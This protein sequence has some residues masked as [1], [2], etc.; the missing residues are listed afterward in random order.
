MPWAKQVV[1]VFAKDVRAQRWLLLVFVA[2]LTISTVG[3]LSV[4]HTG[5]LA[6][7]AADASPTPFD[8]A[9]V[10]NTMVIAG[11]GEFATT[12][13]LDPVSSSFAQIL[14]PF[15]AVL[16]CALIV[17][18]DS[19]TQPSAFWASLPYSRSAVWGA[20]LLFVMALLLATAITWAIPLMI[21]DLT[22]SELPVR[23]VTA[24]MPI[25]LMCVVALLLATAAAELRTVVLFALLLIV[26]AL[27]GS[28]LF[29][30]RDGDWIVPTMIWLLIRPV[31]VIAA[32]W[33]LS[34]VYRTR[35]GARRARIASVG[36]AG[37]VF[38][39]D[40]ME[41]RA[42][43]AE[44]PAVGQVIPGAVITSR[45]EAKRGLGNDS[46]A[47]TWHVRST[48]VPSTMRAS[49]QLGSRFSANP[50]RECISTLL[51][52]SAKS[53]RILQLPP[54]P[55]DGT[56]RWPAGAPRTVDSLSFSVVTWNGVSGTVEADCGARALEAVL[57]LSEAVVFAVLPLQSG[58]RAT[59][60]GQRVEV[61]DATPN[62]SA[63]V[64][65]VVTTSANRATFCSY[66]AATFV[67]VNRGQG[68]AVLLT[69]T[70]Q[71]SGFGAVVCTSSL[72]LSLADGTGHETTWLAMGKRSAEESAAWL[73]DAQLVVIEW[74]PRATV[75]ITPTFPEGA[76]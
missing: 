66:E 71:R 46:L 37:L 1:H 59:G 13:N 14:A 40:V 22:W 45:L 67:L 70:R 19:P 72:I 7:A 75:S 61:L 15:V 9:I 44:L 63:R 53:P 21:L 73:R 35:P 39:P 33:W 47:F 42:P 65:N 6:A 43:V 10:S 8:A 20:K 62:G 11:E 18:A 69:A 16:M 50:R 38:A 27:V 23:L 24:T 4:G 12:L 60:R 51:R 58:A 31:I 56:L 41:I 28:A 3:S 52:M 64:A 76:R 5:D 30:R 32:L 54:L 26:A 36:L 29:A 34:F 48:G 49:L 2:L 25:F 17:V 68:E 57:D 55:I 74:Q